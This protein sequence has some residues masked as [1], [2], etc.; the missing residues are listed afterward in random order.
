MKRRK[1]ELRAEPAATATEK[2]LVEQRNANVT[3]MEGILETARAENR[4]LS[5]E[6][7]TQFTTLESDVSAIDATLDAEAR[8][9]AINMREPNDTTPVH[10][11]A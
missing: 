7:Q 8:A 3:Q 11:Q 4:A 10:P 5:T 2:G 1:L 9:R 6:E